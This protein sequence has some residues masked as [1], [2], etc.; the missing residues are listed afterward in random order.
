M[1]VHWCKCIASSV[2]LISNHCIDKQDFTAN[3][4]LNIY[5]ENGVVFAFVFLC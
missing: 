3:I 1:P 4:G 2:H 5:V